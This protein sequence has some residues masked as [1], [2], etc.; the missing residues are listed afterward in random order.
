MAARTPAP[1][2]L[3]L[4]LAFGATACGG[5]DE[6][7]A[8]S[9]SPSA[10][11]SATPTATPTPLDPVS[12]LPTGDPSTSLPASF[13][14]ADVPVLPGPVTQPIGEGSPEQ[15]WVLEVVAMDRRRIATIRVTPP[16]DR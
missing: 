13:P 10:S 9:G 2:L 8:R 6:K 14:T 11:A 15:G 7:D 4:V 12:G 3:A 1:A 16:G 5:D